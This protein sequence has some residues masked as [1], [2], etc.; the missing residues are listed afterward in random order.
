MIT[1]SIQTGKIDKARLKPY[2]SRDGTVGKSLELV[3]FE[4]KTGKLLVKQS[5]TKEERVA[6]LEMPILGE[7][8]DWSKEKARTQ[9]SAASTTEPPPADDSGVPF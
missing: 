9:Q 4:T 7:A 2:T 5:C 8:R 1:L 3:I 6:R